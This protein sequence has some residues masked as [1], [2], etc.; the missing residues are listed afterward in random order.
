MTREIRITPSILNADFD[1]LDQE[2]A[3]IAGVSDLIHLDVMDNIFV[4]NFTFDFKNHDLILIS[5]YFLEQLL[6]PSLFDGLIHF[7][8]LNLRSQAFDMKFYRNFQAF[9]CYLCQ[10]MK[11]RWGWILKPS[12]SPTI[13]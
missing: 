9:I 5:S 2:I 6:K 8:I 4:P 3:K 10:M 1:H 12:Y 13:P 7:K 11:K